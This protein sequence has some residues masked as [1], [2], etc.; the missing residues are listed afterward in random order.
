MVA[1]EMPMV[2]ILPIE[3]PGPKL[4]TS[5]GTQPKNTYKVVAGMGIPAIGKLTFKDRAG[6]GKAF[7]VKG[8]GNESEGDKVSDTAKNL[9]YPKQEADPANCKPSYLYVI[10]RGNNQKTNGNTLALT[11]MAKDWAKDPVTLMTRP[12]ATELKPLPRESAKFV[13]AGIATFAM[14]AASLY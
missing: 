3:Y 1:P 4:D 8:Q 5:A 2:P 6:L 7:G 12:T 14:V 13:A 11:F 9:V 10:V